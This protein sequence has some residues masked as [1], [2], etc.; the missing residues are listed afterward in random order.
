MPQTV[1]KFFIKAVRVPAGFILSWIGVM[2]PWEG[3]NAYLK[4]VGAFFDIMLQ[5]DNVQ[6]FFM[7]VGFSTE[8]T[9][10]GVNAQND[11]KK[12]RGSLYE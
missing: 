4:V 2:L 10:D 12:N 11:Q 5:S 9:S 1:G 7:N 3:R 8:M 6:R